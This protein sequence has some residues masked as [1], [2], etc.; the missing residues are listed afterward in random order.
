ME[1][2][3]YRREHCGADDEM[4]NLLEYQYERTGA[5]G[6]KAN[7]ITQALCI[8]ALSV[9]YSMKYIRRKQ[10]RTTFSVGVYS[11]YAVF[12]VYGILAGTV[13]KM[14]TA[15]LSGEKGRPVFKEISER[16]AGKL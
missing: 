1:A 12:R 5:F 8:L 9:D 13:C 7:I 2:E 3:R 10:A 6:M 16:M 4:C 15:G 14:Y 11:V